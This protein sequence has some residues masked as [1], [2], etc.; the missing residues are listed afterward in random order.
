MTFPSI[1]SIKGA[2]RNYFRNPKL[3]SELGS[4]PKP[5]PKP[6]KLARNSETYSKVPKRDRNS[7]PITELR[8]KKRKFKN[9]IKKLNENT[10]PLPILTL[11]SG[12]VSKPAFLQNKEEKK[13]QKRFSK[14][15][16]KK[17][18]PPYPFL[19]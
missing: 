17:T 1:F 15:N 12:F 16:N 11:K 3:V 4:D 7:Q 6:P 5:F 19:P 13:R 18:P 10:S 9:L 14:K 2:A 8:S